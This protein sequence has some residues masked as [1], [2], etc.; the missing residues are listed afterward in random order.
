MQLRP[1][2]HYNDLVSY[3]KIYIRDGRLFKT[4]TFIET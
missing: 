2:V 4:L 1:S 3:L